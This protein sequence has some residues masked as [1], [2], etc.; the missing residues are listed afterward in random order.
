MHLNQADRRFELAGQLS[1]IPLDSLFAGGWLVV[2]IAL[3]PFG[4]LLLD[5]FLNPLSV[6]PQ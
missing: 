2:L 6:L 4:L 5:K 1:W 3:L